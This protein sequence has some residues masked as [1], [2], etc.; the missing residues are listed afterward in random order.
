LAASRAVTVTLKGEPAV[1]EAG[2]DTEKCVAAPAVTLIALDV[3]VFEAV[4]VSV[5]VMVCT[6]MV[7][8]VAENVPTPLV[9]VEFAGNPAAPS[10]LVNCTVPR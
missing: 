2:A 10:V 4:T 6:P 8:S 9:S 1:A 7:L 3:P 5:A